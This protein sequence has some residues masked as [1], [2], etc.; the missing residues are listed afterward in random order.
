MLI[1]SPIKQKPPFVPL[2][3]LNRDDAFSRLLR[4]IRKTPQQIAGVILKKDLYFANQTRN[5]G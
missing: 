1:T 2:I 4:L 3:A 5:S